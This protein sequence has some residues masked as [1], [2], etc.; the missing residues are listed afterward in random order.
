LAVTIENG[1]TA[2]TVR[3]EAYSYRFAEDS[4]PVENGGVVYF[5]GVDGFATAVDGRTGETRWRLDLGT[6]ITTTPVTDG[7]DVYAGTADDKMYRISAENGQ[8]LAETR[9]DGR[10]FGKPVLGDDVLVLLADEDLLVAYDRSLSAARWSASADGTWSTH[11]PL[12]WRDLVIVGTR[13]GDVL[14]LRATD[15]TEAFS[16]HLGGV[17][18]GLGASGDVLYIGTLAGS[19]FAYRPPSG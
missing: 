2:W 17:I 16:E 6:R 8:I 11:Q 13:G 4:S 12:L 9:C 10:P 14:G 18:R 15:G 3:P 7:A 1:E 5:G 19:L